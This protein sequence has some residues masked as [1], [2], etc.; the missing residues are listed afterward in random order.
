MSYAAELDA[1]PRAANA[2][3]LLWAGFFAI[4]AAGI[5]FA[6]RGGILKQ[7]ETDFGFSAGQLGQITG[8]GL[9]GF[10]FGI[11]IGG[12]VVDRIG[13]RTLVVVAFLLHLLSAIITFAPGAETPPATA[14]NYLFWGSFI[15][16][17]ANGTLE[18]VANPLVATLFPNDR[19]HYL[20]ILHAGWPLG[21]IIGGAFGALFGEMLTWKQQMAL[22]L[23]PTVGYGLMF[24]GQSFPKSEA[25]SSGL[26]L[27]EMLKDIGL[28]GGAIASAFVGLWLFKDFGPTL[29]RLL[30][31]NIFGTWYFGA[32]IAGL[33][34]LAIA[35]ITGF[36]P[37]HWLIALLFVTHA[38]VGA[39]ELGT[40]SWIQ[41]ITGNILSPTIGKWL[42]VYT[43]LIMFLLRFTAHSIEKTLKLSPVGLLLGCSILAFIGLQFIARAETTSVAMAAL[44]VYGAGKTFFWPT[45]LAVASDRFPRTGAIAISLMGGIGMASAGLLGAPG[46][47]YIK[48][49][50]V[51]DTLRVMDK[52]PD[53]QLINQFKN[54]Q[55]SRFL[56]FREVDGLDGTKVSAIRDK[57]RANKNLPDAESIV[58]R[59][60]READRRVLRLDSVIPLTMA[61]IYLFLLV[62]FRRIGGYRK[63]TIGDSEKA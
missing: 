46:L 57:V 5:G 55:P 30:D 60:D 56:M 53:G 51:S 10:C 40:D 63:L 1:P 3:R 49:R 9:T 20:N 21:L 16:A 41:N 54:E 26:S 23:V 33:L 39:V 50:S 22:F 27:G 37:G 7:W 45:M 19:T 18:A 8:A 11:F 25:S 48:D 44:L 61:L 42:F 32:S 38:L 36:S 24:L 58:Y 29:D 4:L 15:F 34:W 31:T 43:S 17:I 35:V 47:G 13:Y 14:F 28:M 59:A 12:L 2:F 62:Y 6:I 52:S